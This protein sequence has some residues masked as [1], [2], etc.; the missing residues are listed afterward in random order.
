MQKYFE[1]NNMQ[2]CFS[3]LLLTS[4]VPLQ[5]GKCTLTSLGVHVPSLGTPSLGLGVRV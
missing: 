2:T 1:M 5:I 3:L 4:N